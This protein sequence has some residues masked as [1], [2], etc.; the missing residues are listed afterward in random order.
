M[1]RGRGRACMARIR[2][3]HTYGYSLLGAELGDSVGDKERAI[4][5]SC[6]PF[7]SSTRLIYCICFKCCNAIFNPKNKRR[8]LEGSSMT[9][10]GPINTR[11]PKLV[12]YSR[13]TRGLRMIGPILS[14]SVVQHLHLFSWLC[15]SHDAPRLPCAGAYGHVIAWYRRSRTAK[16]SDDR[17]HKMNHNEQKV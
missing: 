1:G 17:K 2:G 6:K 15:S 5:R 11:C 12:H 16:A 8:R 4:T 3:L 13:V 14:R 9:D 7:R 10:V